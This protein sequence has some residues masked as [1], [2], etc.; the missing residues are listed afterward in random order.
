MLRDKNKGFGD[1]P[2]Q[3]KIDEFTRSESER[4]CQFFRKCI[5]TYCACSYAHITN[6]SNSVYI[7][8][9]SWYN[10]VVSKRPYYFRRA[11]YV[12]KN[13]IKEFR[14][15]INLTQYQLAKKVGLTRRGILQM[16][17]SD[18]DI[19]IS[20]AIRISKALEKKVEEVFILCEE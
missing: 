15:D 4:I 17:K 10:M 3:A 13:K 12:I 2:Q 18:S 19:K 7:R 9:I 16:E 14:K 5:C 1:I 8:K 20:N 6:S 11:K